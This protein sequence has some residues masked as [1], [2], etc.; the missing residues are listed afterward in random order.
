M[1]L[2]FVEGASIAGLAALFLLT[3]ATQFDNRFSLFLRRR[4]FFGILPQWNFFAPTPG[5][6]DYYLLFRDELADGSVTPWREI[7][8]TADRR[9]H[10]WAWH[11]ERRLKKAL[12]D[13]VT[14]VAIHVRSGL[15]DV[16]LTVAYL[17]LLNFVA[18]YPRLYRFE[19]TQ[20]LVMM[21]SAEDADGEPSEVMLS[22]LHPR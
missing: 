12:F 15:T 2:T 6:V 20:F 4:D 10:H 21:S 1:G 3:V 7:P 9:W 17:V 14:H 11:P 5:T 16:R 18:E 19:K 13:A 8:L 22:E